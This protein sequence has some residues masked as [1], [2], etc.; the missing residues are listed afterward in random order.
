[1]PFLSFYNSV[2]LV[3]AASLD[4][5][6]HTSLLAM[7]VA[8]PLLYAASHDF[9]FA[10]CSI[11]AGAAS[12]VVNLIGRNEGGLTL[13]REAADSVLRDFKT[14]FSNLRRAKYSPKRPLTVAKSIVNMVISD[15]NTA[16]VVEHNGAIDAL[17]RQSKGDAVSVSRGID[18]FQLCQ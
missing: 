16:F 9:T 14:L 6:R 1:M 5:S 2:N 15:A 18:G 17:Y 10:G 13:S 12:A 4:S 7:G 3:F 11:A 8:K